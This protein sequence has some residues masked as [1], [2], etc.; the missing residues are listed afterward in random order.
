MKTPFSQYMDFVLETASRVILNLDQS[1]SGNSIK[2]GN[3]Q[4]YS[5]LQASA[6]GIKC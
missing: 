5:P 6:E 1:A 3:L 2:Y 4:A